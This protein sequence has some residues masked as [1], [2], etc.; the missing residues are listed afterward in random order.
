MN[1]RMTVGELFASYTAAL[2]APERELL[3][4]RTEARYGGIM[5]NPRL[6]RIRPRNPVCTGARINS[7]KPRQAQPSP[8][9]NLDLRCHAKPRPTTCTRSRKLRHGRS[10]DAL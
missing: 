7:D 5:K 2:C 6:T 8:A 3:R 9:D 4:E 10:A 1:L